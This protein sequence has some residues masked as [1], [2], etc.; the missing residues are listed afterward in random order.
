MNKQ[1]ISRNRIS[2]TVPA[3]NNTM[4]IQHDVD[5]LRIEEN[6]KEPGFVKGTLEDAIKITAYIKQVILRYKS[7]IIK[8]NN[9]IQK[10]ASSESGEYDATFW[11]QRAE[12]IP[13]PKKNKPH[14]REALPPS[15][16]LE[17]AYAEVP[18]W[19]ARHKKVW[20]V[21]TTEEEYYKE[22]GIE[23]NNDADSELLNDADLD[24]FF[25]MLN[26]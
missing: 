16:K 4:D 3:L 25:E 6:E 7:Y 21:S 1:K 23:N 17:K 22:L 26:D 11:Y 10:L 5:N 9:A 8:T 12:H 20:E 24:R 15:D 2:W 18:T 14:L 19:H 13:E